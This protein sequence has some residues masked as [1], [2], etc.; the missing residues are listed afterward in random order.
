MF[1]QYDGIDLHRVQ[2]VLSVYIGA[3]WFLNVSTILTYIETAVCT[4]CLYWHMVVSECFHNTDL[5]EDVQSVYTACFDD[6][7]PECEHTLSHCDLDLLSL[8][9]DVDKSP[10]NLKY[11]L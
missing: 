4:I 1:L 5:H 7:N 10:H 6:Q 11:V 8:R 9:K 2:D 3:W